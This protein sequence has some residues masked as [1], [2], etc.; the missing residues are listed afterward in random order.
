M[1]VNNKIL[2]YNLSLFLSLSLSLYIQNL[3]TKLIIYHI[4]KKIL[5]KIKELDKTM[6][7]K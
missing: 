3:Y 6:T 4:Y 5:L 1:D 2:F 7:F